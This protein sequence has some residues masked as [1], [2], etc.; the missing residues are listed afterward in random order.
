MTR[1]PSARG[2]FL[3]T[4]RLPLEEPVRDPHDYYPT[5]WEPTHAFLNAERQH[6]LGAM[7]FDTHN[8]AIWEPAAGDGAMARVMEVQGLPVYCS[9][10]V[11]RGLP[12]CEIRDFFDFQTPRGEVLITNPPYA[13]TSARGKA[14]WILHARSLGVRYMALLL[15]WDWCAAKALAPVLDEWPISRVYVCRW[16]VDFTGKGAPPQRNAW[17][18][19]DDTWR[20]ETA[21]RYLDRPSPKENVYAL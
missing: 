19:W 2:L 10:L 5:P 12:F 9:D 16:K 14:R 20:G 1:A 8:G 4:G 3:A 18:V 13:L 15:N 21:L 6:I 7:R 11:D 17:F